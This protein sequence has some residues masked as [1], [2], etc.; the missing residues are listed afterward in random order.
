MTETRCLIV[1]NSPNS[2]PRKL[3]DWL[4]LEDVA[5]DVVLGSAGLPTSLSGYAGMILLG[6]GLLPTDDE[7]APWLKAERELAAWAIA[8]DFPT[9]GICL[10]GQ[11]LAHVAGGTVKAKYGCVERGATQII[12]TPAGRNDQLLSALFP[13]A[14]MIENHEDQITELPPA[15]IHLAVS[16]A[17]PAQAFRLGEKVWGLQFHPEAQAADIANWDDA[18]L[19]AEGLDREALLQAAHNAHEANT[20]A[21]EKLVRAFARVMKQHANT[22]ER[23]E[24]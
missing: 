2:G 20:L 8:N 13:H 23:E 18:A 19:A 11:L 14:P 7:K 6:G 24:A 21:A 15:A 3:L 16:T 9:L 5:Y 10:G 22:Q 4:P 17:V 12:A 1:Q